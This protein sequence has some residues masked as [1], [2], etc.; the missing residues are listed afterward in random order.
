MFFK[1]KKQEPKVSPCDDPTSIGNILI[2]LGFITREEFDEKIRKFQEAKI[3]TLLGQFLV[4]EGGVTPQQLERALMRQVKM[5]NG[6]ID[7]DSIMKIL[8]VAKKTQESFNKEVSR[9]EKFTELAEAKVSG[10]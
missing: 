9:F 6:G 10:K 4:I 2:E 3:E 8:D 5:R 7:H 1:T